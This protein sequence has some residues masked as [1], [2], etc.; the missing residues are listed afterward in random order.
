MYICVFRATL[1]V[2]KTQWYRDV[3]NE[4]ERTHVQEVAALG[5]SRLMLA[6][7]G[8]LPWIRDPRYPPTPT[9]HHAFEGSIPIVNSICR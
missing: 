7:A 3:Q 2:D 6:Q 4:I 8:R 5:V 1:D 9:Q